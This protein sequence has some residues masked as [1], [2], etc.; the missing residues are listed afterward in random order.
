MRRVEEDEH[1][2]PTFLDFDNRS[3]IVKLLK[4]KIW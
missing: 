3:V 1:R 4:A 2:V